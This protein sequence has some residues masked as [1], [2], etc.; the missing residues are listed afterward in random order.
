MAHG[1][2]RISGHGWMLAR[3]ISAPRPVR[4]RCVRNLHGIE[5]VLGMANLSDEISFATLVSVPSSSVRL[6]VIVEQRWVPP[7]SQVLL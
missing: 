1:Q 7:T 5:I 3:A 2:E 4:M 6:V